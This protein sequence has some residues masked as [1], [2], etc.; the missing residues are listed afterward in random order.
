MTFRRWPKP[1]TTDSEG[2]FTL[3]GLGRDL[4]VRSPSITRGLPSRPFRSRRTTLRNR[5]RSPRRWY[6]PR[7]ST[8]ADLCRHGRAACLMPSSRCWPATGGPRSSPDSRPTTADGFAVNPPPA[9]GVYNVTAY[10]PEGQPYLVA[11]R[12]SCGPRAH[13][14]SPSNS[15]CLAASRSAASVTEEGSGKP[16]AGCDRRLRLLVRQRATTRRARHATHR[17]MARFN[18]GPRPGPGYLFI[19]GPSDD[20]VLQAIGSRMDARRRAGRPLDVFAWPTACS[21]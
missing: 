7:S 16:V 2:R 11:R 21:T 13:S 1:V 6:R 10:P 5:S 9:D 15:P 18:S 12:A 3:R 17:P 19:R 20:Y 14:S 4:S 8:G